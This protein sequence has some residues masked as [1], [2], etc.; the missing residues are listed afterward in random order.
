MTKPNRSAKPR[1]KQKPSIPPDLLRFQK[2]EV[3]PCRYCGRAVCAPLH[4]IPKEKPLDPVDFAHF[5]Y[6]DKPLLPFT[7]NHCQT[8]L[9]HAPTDKL[10]VRGV[11]L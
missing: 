10:M 3:L 5:R 6:S 11:W 8:S 4:D 1:I 9:H 2:S 7:C